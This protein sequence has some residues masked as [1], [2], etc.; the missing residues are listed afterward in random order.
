MDGGPGI[1]TASYFTEIAPVIVDLSITGAQATGAGNDTLAGFENLVGG[2]GSDVLTGNSQSN[3]IEGGPGSDTLDGT[4]GGVDTLVGG[5]GNDTLVVH[6]PADVVI[7]SVQAG[8]DTVVAWFD[9][10][11]GDNFENLTLA[12]DSLAVHAIGNGANNVIVGNAQANVISG[13]AGNDSLSG[14]DGDDTLDAGAGNDT[15][16][17]GNGTDTVIYT[18]A[19]GAVFDLA[20][21]D[22]NHMLGVAA[23]PVISSIENAVGGEGN[24]VFYGSAV[25]NHIEGLGGN[26]TLWGGSGNDTLDGGE[27]IDYAQYI[28][29]LSDFTVTRTATGVTVA[30]NLHSDDADT[31]IGIERLAFRGYGI[32][33]D[34]DGH[35][36]E[37]YRLYQAAF[38]RKPDLPGLGYQMHDLDIGVS[39]W[40]VAS[41]FIA[42]P[43]FQST[44]G[45]LDNTQF[46]TLLYRNVLHREPE[47]EGLAYHLNEFAQ[48]Q[49]RADMLTHFSESP[50]NQV[51][52]IGDIQNGMVYIW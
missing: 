27:G 4:P 9:Y 47:A 32:A 45:N 18:G 17:G 39:L 6:A 10:A 11:L 26:D 12:E 51:N 33:F 37:A 38:D 30:S 1:D 48:G 44:Y 8:I 14:L 29:N 50:E 5:L 35:A 19:G 31:L 23:S 20:Y 43:E 36:G 41:N 24:D 16:D 25:A 13:G 2:Y 7:E 15:L 22:R 21:D 49:D 40:Q 46:I 3:R 34:T 28:G 42:S 52:V